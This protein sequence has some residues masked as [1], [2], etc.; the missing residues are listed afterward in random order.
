MATLD[1]DPATVAASASFQVRV[2]RV[3]AE[4]NPCQEDNYYVANAMLPWGGAPSEGLEVLRGAMACRQWDEFPPFFYGFNQ[5]FFN[6]DAK[7]ARRALEMAAGRARSPQNAATMRRV[8]IMI[9][10]GE[11]ADD[12][13]ALAFLEREREQAVDDKLI[14][15]LDKRVMRLQGLIVLR[16]AQAQY[17]ATTGRP[18]INPQALLDSGVLAV[19][20]QDPLRLGYEFVDGRFRLREMKIPGAER[21]Q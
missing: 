17:E 18:L 14:E 8:G 4:L 10:A 15:M 6:R 16:E 13:A 5:W 7:E 21:R 2:H 9:E 12:R 3:V 19:L 1:D 20:P 11:Y